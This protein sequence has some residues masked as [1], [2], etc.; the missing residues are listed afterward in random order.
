MVRPNIFIANGRKSALGRSRGQ[1]LATKFVVL[2]ICV[3]YEKSVHY[4]KSC[5]PINSAKTHSMTLNILGHRYICNTLH[6]L[7][8]ILLLCMFEVEPTFDQ[9]L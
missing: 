1:F 2:I 6:P 3:I 8:L 5:F 4:F 7:S 9:S